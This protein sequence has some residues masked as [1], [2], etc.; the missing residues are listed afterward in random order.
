MDYRDNP[1]RLATHQT[2]W[3]TFTPPRWTK[4]APPLT[5][6]VACMMA[7]GMAEFDWD[8]VTEYAPA[9]VCAFTMPFTFSI[10]TGIGF[11]FITYAVVKI[12]SGRFHEASWPVLVIAAA[13]V[14]KFIVIPG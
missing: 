11:G 13:F 6:F 7:R 2:R 4:F 5:V 8:D 12:L 14:V 1:Q 9:V 3:T 10:A